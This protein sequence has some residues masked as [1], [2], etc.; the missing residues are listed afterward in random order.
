M[1]RRAFIL[2]ILGLAATWIAAAPSA[3]AAICNPAD[4][5]SF[6]NA[7]QVLDS[8]YIPKPGSAAYRP[9]S[10]V[11]LNL[12]A[13]SPIITDLMNAFQN[14]PPTF[15]ARLCGTAGTPG[16]AGIFI[17][18]VGCAQNDPTRCAHTSGGPNFNRAWG[19][20]SHTPGAGDFGATYI[21]I[22]AADLWQAGNPARSLDDYET[23]LLRSF[24]GSGA[25]MIAPAAPNYSWMSVLAALA[26][27][28]GHVRWAQTVIPITN[29]SYNLGLLV[30]CPAGDFFVGWRYNDPDDL[31]PPNRWR[32]FANRSNA[33]GRRIDHS[34][35]PLLSDLDHPP[36]PNVPLW[37]LYQSNQPWASLFAAQTPDEDFVESYVMAVLTGYDPIA[38]KFTGPLTSMPLNVPGIAT[39]PDVASDLVNG[40]K[41]PLQNKLIC[42]LL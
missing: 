7:V 8:G 2:G 1:I 31:V 23:Q 39:S 3:L 12:P 28:L 38:K 9:P 36:N 18:A 35:P 21:A 29:G 27:E 5:Q 6:V 4:A 37:T 26:H 32:P 25:A 20:R 17:N 15:R 19:F 41:T 14:A 10:G 33:S 34:N 22:A 16:L 13:N 42:I 11:S 40:R 30:N 24:P